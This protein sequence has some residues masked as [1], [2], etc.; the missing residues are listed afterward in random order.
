M[1][2][3]NNF[4]NLDTVFIDAGKLSRNRLDYFKNFVDYYLFIITDDSIA[5]INQEK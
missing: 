1:N 3:A 4:R 5:T 2:K